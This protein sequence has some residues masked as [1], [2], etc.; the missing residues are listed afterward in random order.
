M[1]INV[2]PS[3]N[4][5]Q[6]LGQNTYDYKDLLSELIDNS[7]AAREGRTVQVRIDLYV[8]KDQRA[9]RF[10]IADDAAG[11]PEDKLGS[12]ISPAGL[13]TGG[14][15]NEH[16]LGMK[17]AV[18]ALGQLESLVT[19]TADRE[20]AIEINEFRFGEIEGTEKPFDGTSGTVITVRGLKPMVVTNATSYTRSIVP[21]LGARYRRFLRPDNPILVLTLSIRNIDTSDVQYSWPVKEVKPIYFHPSTRENRPVFS[22]FGIAGS[23]WRAELTFGYAPKDTGEYEELAGC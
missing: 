7:L 18:A 23:G 14:S 3:D 2:V 16:G 6:E 5:F 9:H 17:Q 8:D 4:I 22:K 19:K 12:A 13:K 20:L 10:V 11:I 15:L 1:K 21:Y